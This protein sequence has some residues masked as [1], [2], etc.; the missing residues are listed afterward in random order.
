MH[1]YN[2]KEVILISH[3]HWL[4]NWWSHFDLIKKHAFCD[5]WRHYCHHFDVINIQPFN[6][7]QWNVHILKGL[8][9]H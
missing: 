9:Y 8:G 4:K 1:I 3:F 5:A 2:D 6:N 7:S